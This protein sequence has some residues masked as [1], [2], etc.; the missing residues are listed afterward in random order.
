MNKFVFVSPMYNASLTL[1]R[2]LH[3]IFGQSYENWKIIL[4]DDVSDDKHKEKQKE[5]LE[6]FYG[7]L[8]DNDIKNAINTMHTRGI[9]VKVGSKLSTNGRNLA[10]IYR[11]ASDD[12]IPTV[13]KDNSRKRLTTA[14]LKPE[15]RKALMVKYMP[16]FFLYAKELK[17]SK[18]LLK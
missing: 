6:G 15:V 9:L 1:S 11:L 3:S 2:M 7:L 5:I 18:E 8:S 14:K 4:I 17:L 16:Q 12:D 13:N 10:F